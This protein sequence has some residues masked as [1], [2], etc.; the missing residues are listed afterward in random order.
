MQE[1]WDTWCVGVPMVTVPSPYRSILGP[2]LEY[3]E[4]TDREHD[5]GQHAVLVL[6]EFIPATWWEHL[7]HNQTAWM[8]KLAVLYQRRFHGMGRIVVEVPFYLENL[9]HV[10][11]WDLV[12]VSAPCILGAHLADSDRSLLFKLAKSDNLWKRRV[13][14][15]ATLYFIRQKDFDDTIRIAEVLIK[16]RHDLIHKAV[17]WM[18]REVGK[19]DTA[20]L[21][22]FLARNHASMPRT[23]LRYAIERLPEK[24]RKFYMAR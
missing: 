4:R 3:L 9:D 6:P 23:M 11:N 8:I 14:I 18:L 21:E 16:D 2:L 20:V 17:G 13:A 19:K 22:N 15:V 1:S 12:D 10:N 7:L 24:K 5:D